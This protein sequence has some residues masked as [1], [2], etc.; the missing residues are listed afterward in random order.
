MVVN[1][2]VSRHSRLS[3]LWGLLFLGSASM[4]MAVSGYADYWD[5]TGKFFDFLI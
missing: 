2:N 1:V 5:S 3:R 4:L